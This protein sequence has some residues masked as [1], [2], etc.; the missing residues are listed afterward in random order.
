MV[1]DPESGK[2]KQKKQQAMYPLRNISCLHFKCNFSSKEGFFEAINIQS[3]NI[4]TKVISD[5]VFKKDLT[6]LNKCV[7]KTCF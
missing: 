2:K 7:N 3:P 6:P 5:Y 1:V 4:L